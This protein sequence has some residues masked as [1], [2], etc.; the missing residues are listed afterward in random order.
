MGT[1]CFHTLDSY[2]EIFDSFRRFPDFSAEISKVPE[3]LW[4]RNFSDN[5]DNDRFDHGN[6]TRVLAQRKRLIESLSC[7]YTHT[8]THTHTSVVTRNKRRS[9]ETGESSRFLS[10]GELAASISRSHSA[11]EIRFNS[12]DFR[13]KD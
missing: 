4:P 10:S 3:R 11:D 1:P 8:H 2:R 12:A 5:S 7:I 13:L 6:G 9:R